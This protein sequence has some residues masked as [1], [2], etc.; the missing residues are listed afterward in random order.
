MSVERRF[1]RR[2]AITA[3]GALLLVGCESVEA[4]EK[5]FKQGDII[6]VGNQGFSLRNGWTYLIPD[7]PKFL[8]NIKA[9]QY[10]IRVK[11]LRSISEVVKR[12]PLKQVDNYDYVVDTFS[13]SIKYPKKN[14]G[15]VNFYGSG[16]L[17]ADNK[18]I[19]VPSREIRPNN[20]FFSFEDKLKKEGNFGIHDSVYF[21]YGESHFSRYDAQ[22]TFR[23][24]EIN[25]GHALKQ[26]EQLMIDFPF[27]QFN[28]IGHSL[29][30]L[31]CLAIAMK[32]PYAINNLIL[33]SSPVRGIERTRGRSIVQ[34]LKEELPF[35]GDEKVSEYLFRRWESPTFG[36]ELDAFGESF[37]R[38]RKKL[39]VAT[40]EDDPFIPK[41]SV[42]IKGATQIILPA[43]R[44]SASNIQGHGR[45][46]G[47]LAVL[48]PGTQGIGKNR[49]A[50]Y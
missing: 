33:L 50:V 25:I 37:T 1:S 5:D 11:D 23:D 48:N 31:F 28:L 36:Q 21:S 13:Q 7:L 24:P 43:V 27:A 20:T 12:F 26:F 42:P 41:E 35:I 22:D 3:M 47:E 17:T 19:F 45:T 14:G 15:E 18:G 40:A 8:D 32:Y 44:S 49:A 16:F 9:E 30:G 6:R 34:R 39:L 4:K 38:S 29:G 46:L 2:H 10:G